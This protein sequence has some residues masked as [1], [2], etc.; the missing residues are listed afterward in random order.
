MT[1][2]GENSKRTT[3]SRCSKR[4]GWNTLAMCLFCI[5]KEWPSWTAIALNNCNIEQFIQVF[6]LVLISMFSAKSVKYILLAM[7]SSVDPPF[8]SKAKVNKSIWQFMVWGIF[9]AHF[10]HVLVHYLVTIALTVHKISCNPTSKSRQSCDLCIVQQCVDKP[11]K[12]PTFRRAAV[13]F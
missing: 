11:V 5:E 13:D 3:C 12:A 1:V 10:K 8:W 4:F 9:N 2:L 6:I 7:P